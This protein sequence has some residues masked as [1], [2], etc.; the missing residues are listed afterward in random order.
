M[1][2]LI[3]GKIQEKTRTHADIYGRRFPADFFCISTYDIFRKQ[4]KVKILIDVPW[5]SLIIQMRAGEYKQRTSFCVS[6]MWKLY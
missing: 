1:Y 3:G 2:T 6:I 5:G 4:M